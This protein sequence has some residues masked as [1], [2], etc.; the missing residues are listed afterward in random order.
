MKM[1]ERG[2]YLHSEFIKDLDLNISLYGIFDTHKVKWN[3]YLISISKKNKELT[4]D[5]CSKKV[6]AN[7]WNVK[8]Y[9]KQ[10]NSIDEGVNYLKDFKL[11][12]ETGNNNTTAEIRDEKINKILGD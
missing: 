11:K 1:A 10:V 5:I 2:K 12:W 9:G 3:Y 7:Q 4:D 6:P 8:M